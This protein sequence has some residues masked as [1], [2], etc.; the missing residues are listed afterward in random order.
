MLVAK[1]IPIRYILGKIKY[2][3]LFMLLIGIIIHTITTFFENIIPKM[4]ITIPAFLGTSI[5][6]ILSFKLSQSYD[7][8]WEARKIWGSIVNDARTLTIQIQSFAPVKDES[9]KNISY[10]QI[11]WCYSLGQSLRNLNPLENISKFLKD[12]EIIKIRWHTN[13][14]L[15]IL[16]LNSAEI[17]ALHAE[18]K[19]DDFTRMQMDNT[20]VRLCDSMGRAERIK[21]TVFPNTYRIYLHFIIYLFVI[22]LSI[23]LYDLEIYYEIPLLAIISSCFFLL[24]KSAY[25]MQD[26]FSNRPSDT[27]VTTIA[28][29]IEINIR[30][31]LG[32]EDVPEPVKPN[33]FYIL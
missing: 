2:D 11:A 31:L 32:E 22:S 23:S 5:S 30:Q 33:D 28:R 20:L 9:I 6:V 3:I 13:I 29:T 18:K 7:R 8:W 4:P 26:P 27:P 24:E 21:S 19:I 1:K 15:A 12:E 10:R 17:A 25:H 16:K 14:P